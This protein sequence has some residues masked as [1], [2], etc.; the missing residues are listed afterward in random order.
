MSNINFRTTPKGFSAD[1]Q[2]ADGFGFERHYYR[3]SDIKDLAQH[4]GWASC[5][6]DVPGEGWTV[7]EMLIQMSDYPQP[8]RT[9]TL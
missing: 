9:V 5:D 7:A 2:R 6:D 4:Y 1:W 8:Y 3:R